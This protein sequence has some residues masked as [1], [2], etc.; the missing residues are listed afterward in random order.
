MQKVLFWSLFSRFRLVF[1]SLGIVQRHKVNKCC[2][3]C[4]INVC[5][6]IQ[7]CQGDITFFLTN[8]LIKVNILGLGLGLDLFLSIY[9]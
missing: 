7:S 6:S 1:F 4:H 8:P 9:F 3:V 2:L 5:C